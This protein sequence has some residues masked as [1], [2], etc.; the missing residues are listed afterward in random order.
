MANERADGW[1]GPSH[2]IRGVPGPHRTTE[3]DT[4]W[5]RDPDPLGGYTDLRVP[6]TPQHKPTRMTR[7]GPR[8]TVPTVWQV[9]A[10]SHG[11]A[12]CVLAGTGASGGASPGGGGLGVTELRSQGPAAPS[13]ARLPQPLPF[14]ALGGHGARSFALALARNASPQPQVKAE[15]VGSE[16]GASQRSRHHTRSF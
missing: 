15:A 1:T 4:A 16:L 2:T 14:L 9:R 7:P 13:P 6:L 11:R 8:T 5:R 12:S 10:P 3:G